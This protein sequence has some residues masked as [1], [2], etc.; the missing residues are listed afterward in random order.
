MHVHAKRAFETPGAAA[1]S[2]RRLAP[3]RGIPARGVP[4]HAWSIA[5]LAIERPAAS[6]DDARAGVAQLKRKKK[7][8]NRADFSRMG[9]RARRNYLRAQRELR[10]RR[11]QQEREEDARPALPEHVL[12]AADERAWNVSREATQGLIPSTHGAAKVSDDKSVRALQSMDADAQTTFPYRQNLVQVAYDPTIASESDADRRTG[13]LAQTF[14]HELAVHGKNVGRKEVDVE[15]REMHDPDTRQEYL[16][17]SRATF[18]SLAGARQKRAFAADWEADMHNQI[19]DSGVYNEDTDETETL[20]R[21][22]RKRRHAWA[23][24]RAQSMVHAIKKPGK[25]PWTQS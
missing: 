17:A 5:S 2:S 1:A 23:R 18:T 22:A 9:R 19:S 8:P 6:A 12:D 13:G 11:A 21:G 4:A 16:D 24:A 14:T 15:H 3:A 25:H 20:S 7:N 10:T